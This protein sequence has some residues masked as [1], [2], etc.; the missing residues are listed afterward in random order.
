MQDL[1][2][3]T[4]EMVDPQYADLDLLPTADAVAAMNEAEMSVPLAIRRAAPQIVAAI[5]AIHAGLAR[6]GRL[7]Y[8]GAGTAGRLGVLDAAECPPTFSTDTDLV[9]G[10]IAGGQPALTTAIEGAED[11]YDAGYDEIASL[12]VGPDDAVVGISASGRTPFAVG[13]VTA[14][15]EAGA[16]TVGISNNADSLLSSSVD[17]PIEA[18]VGPE[19]LSGSTRLKAGSAQK[20]I[21]NMISTLTM[22]KLGKVYGN[23]MVDVNATNQKLEVRAQRLVMQ[24]TGVDAGTAEEALQRAHGSVKLAVV[25]LLRGV[26]VDEANEILDEHRGFLRSALDGNDPLGSRG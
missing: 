25:T 6:G 9:Q 23:L 13:G 2:T 17:F 15:R 21:L 8:I 26:P 1:A 16:V 5:D 12:G 22:V 20:Q 10:I 19:V 24:I 11:D 3:F 14:A 4:T 18:V 7:I